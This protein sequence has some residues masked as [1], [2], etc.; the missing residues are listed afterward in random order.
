MSIS[1]TRRVKMQMLRMSTKRF[2]YEPTDASYIFA[3]VDPDLAEAEED[4]I[5]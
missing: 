4:A 2:S 3:D 5:N 1:C